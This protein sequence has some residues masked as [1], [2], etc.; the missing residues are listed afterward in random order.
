MGEMMAYAQVAHTATPEINRE[1]IAPM[2]MKMFEL[3]A[4]STEEQLDALG[5]SKENR[6]ALKRYREG[7]AISAGRDMLDRAGNLLAIHKNLRLLFPRNPELRYG[8]MKTRNKAFQGRTPVETI[9]EMG[10]S[11]LLY[12]RSYLDRVRGN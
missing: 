10:F 3:W 4:L 5:L 6:T 9:Q 11:G 7:H 8:W 1:K 12:V 2:L